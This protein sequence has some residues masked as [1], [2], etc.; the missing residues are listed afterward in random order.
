MVSAR[1]LIAAGIAEGIGN[2][3]ITAPVSDVVDPPRAPTGVSAAG[4]LATI[5]VSWDSPAY[6]GHAYS[7]IWA[8]SRTQAQT[9]AAPPENPIIGQAELVGM[10]AGNNFSH[11]LGSGAQRWYWVRFVNRNGVA[12]PYNLTDGTFGQTSQD[13]EYMLEVLTDAVT[14]SQLASTLLANINT[15]FSQTDAPEQKADGSALVAGDLWYDTNDGNK[16]YRFDGDLW[17]NAQDG[18]IAQAIT[19]AGGAQGTADGKIT[20]YYQDASPTNSEGTLSEGD[21]WV[22]TDDGNNL[23]RWDATGGENETG[24]MDRHSRHWHRNRYPRRVRRTKH[25]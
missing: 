13:P 10:T 1:Q 16:L 3:G 25:R 21:L 17:V 18:G 9:D 14:S 5:I 15:T 19:D 2:G 22:D 12:G 8:A 7:E 4:A 20:T 11:N 24:R 6:R 23:Y